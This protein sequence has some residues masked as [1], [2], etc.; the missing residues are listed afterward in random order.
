RNRQIDRAPADDV[1]FARVRAALVKI[2]I[3]SAPSEICREQPT[4]QSAADQN[5]S[6]HPARIYESG[7]QERRKSRQGECLSNF[8]ASDTDA[9]Q[10]CEG[11]AEVI[12][13]VA[14]QQGLL[15]LFTVKDSDL[16]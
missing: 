4:R 16:R 7:K 13:N 8:T 5:K 15:G 2:H 3:V 10:F 11:V 12:E 1:P 6:C 9:L 14:R